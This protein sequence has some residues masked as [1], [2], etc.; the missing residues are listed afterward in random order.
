MYITKNTIVLQTVRHASFFLQ[1][2]T[3]ETCLIWS[4]L[5]ETC[6]VCFATCETCL[7]CSSTFETCLISSERC[8][9]CLVCF[10]SCTTCLVCFA[11]CETCLFCST[12]CESCSVF[13]CSATCETCLIFWQYWILNLNWEREI[14]GRCLHI[15]GPIFYL[16]LGGLPSF[17]KK[18]KKFERDIV[19]GNP[20]S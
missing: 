1:P 19:R 16:Y 4:E 8:K 9:T 2:P 5:C 12:S 15:F 13:I 17:Q 10:A 3:C 18:L 7:I 20:L 11:S 6:L 14:F